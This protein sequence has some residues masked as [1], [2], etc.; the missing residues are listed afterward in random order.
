MCADPSLSNHLTFLFSAESH[1]YHANTTGNANTV[2]LSG[3]RPLF[4]R[5]AL[6]KEEVVGIITRVMEYTNRGD[7]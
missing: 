1:Y 3:G 2:S 7:Y 6:S 4:T 5:G